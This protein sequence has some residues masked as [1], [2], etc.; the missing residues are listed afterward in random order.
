MKTFNV[1]PHSKQ[2][3]PQTYQS[4]DTALNFA[5]RTKLSHEK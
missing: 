2:N 4:Y 3:N 5:K 1:K